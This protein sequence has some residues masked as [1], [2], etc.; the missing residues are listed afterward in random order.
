M[1][2]TLFVKLKCQRCGRE[3]RIYGSNYEYLF[4]LRIEYAVCPYCGHAENIGNPGKNEFKCKE[5]H[6]VFV[7]SP[8]KGMCMSCYM[9][10]RR[11]NKKFNTKNMNR[12]NNNNDKAKFISR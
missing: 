10:K 7:G 6:V 1:K 12:Y 3:Y 2:P 11:R 4:N 8:V 9:R 5:C